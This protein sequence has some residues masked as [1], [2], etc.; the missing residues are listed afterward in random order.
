MINVNDILNTV[1]CA[2]CLDIMKQ[3]PDKC[4]DLVLTDPPYGLGDKLSKGA[5]KHKNLRMRLDYESGSQW[6]EKPDKNYFNEIIRVSKNQIIWG[7]NYFALPPC[8]GFIVWDKKQM[9]PTFSQVEYAWTS[10]DKPSKMYSQRT[11]DEQETRCH[12]TQK[13]KNLMIWILQNYSTPG[14]TIFDPFAG[15][16]TTAIACLETGRNYIC[17]EKEPDYVEI[18]NKRIATW[19]EQGR[20]FA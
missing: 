1:H 14:M 15:S 4:I 17:I 18:I 2:D 6:D 8:R 20:M 5:G 13:P 7:G 16:G 10:F 12:P 9:M 11:I 3:L 19:K